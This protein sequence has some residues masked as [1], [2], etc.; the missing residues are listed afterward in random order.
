MGSSQDTTAPVP[1]A[2]LHPELWI[3]MM[4]T[5]E[6]EEKMRRVMSCS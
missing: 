6:E 2:R 4:E 1:L 3:K 5:S